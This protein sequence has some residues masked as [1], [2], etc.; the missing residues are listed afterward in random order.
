MNRRV[1]PDR[2]RALTIEFKHAFEVRGV[3]FL[4][5]ATV[6]FDEYGRVGE[7]FL[8]ANKTSTPN[9]AYARDAAIA[10]SFAFQYGASVDTLRKAMS[11][12]AD[13]HPMSP[14]GALLD[15]LSTV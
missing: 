13:G 5:K 9:D 8:N 10:L 6:G 7:V 3:P 4:Y 2:R 12:T 14:I 11:R 15:E 1:L